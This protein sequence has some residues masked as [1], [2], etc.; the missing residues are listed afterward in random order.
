MSARNG[1][2]VHFRLAGFTGAPEH[3]A[4]GHD[5][6]VPMDGGRLA[7]ALEARTMGPDTRTSSI[8]L[9]I[10]RIASSGHGASIVP[11]TP[12]ETIGFPSRVCLQF[13]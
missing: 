5:T 11:Y 8:V 10:G 4:A 1:R 9:G 2:S 7:Q 13:T 3:R 12:F 6:Q